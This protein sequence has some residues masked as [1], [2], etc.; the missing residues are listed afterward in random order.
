[1]NYEI[2]IFK[3]FHLT[4]TLIHLS[5]FPEDGDRTCPRNI[6]VLIILNTVLWK[7]IQQ[8]IPYPANV[9]NK[10]RS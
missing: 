9:K 5:V 6:I 10:L 4:H 8:F 7:K 3:I 1:M 2:K